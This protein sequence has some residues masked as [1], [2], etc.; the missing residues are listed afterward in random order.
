MR[1]LFA[2]WPGYGHLLPMAPLIRAAQHGGHDVAVSSGADM[3]ELIGKLG[4]SAHRSR[5]T[6]AESYLRMPGGR[7]ARRRRH[8]ARRAV[9]RPCAAVPAAVQALGRLPHQPSFEQATARLRTEIDQ[10]PSASV[11]DQVI[12]NTSEAVT[13]S[14][15]ADLPASG[16]RLAGLPFTR[17]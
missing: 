3:A 15:P 4:V 14:R 1:I 6:L 9:P 10:M 8:H 13:T 7:I 16:E 11:L 2:S 12:R 5:V 17:E